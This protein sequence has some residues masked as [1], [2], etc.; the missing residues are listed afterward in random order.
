MKNT[1]S[2]TDILKIFLFS[3]LQ[4][5][6]CLF[7]G[8]GILPNLILLI[9]FFR[10][11]KNKNQNIL[12]SSMSFYKYYIYIVGLLTFLIYSYIKVFIRIQDI[13]MSSYVIGYVVGI[14]LT[15][16]FIYGFYLVIL[17]FLFKRTIFNHKKEKL[18]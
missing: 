16:S 5:P 2:S 18:T 15:V 17:E 7:V 12:L 14:F 4:I 13:P 6:L 10:A 1:L 8:L 9:G 11:R 3:I